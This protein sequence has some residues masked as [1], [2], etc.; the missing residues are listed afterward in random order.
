MISIREFDQ[1]IRDWNE[2]RKTL[3]LIAGALPEA[4]DLLVL[5]MQ[6]GLDFQV[7]LAH[8][9]E[10]APHGPLW[11]ELSKLQMEIRT[12]VSRVEALRHLAQR[13][14]ETGL[15]EMARAIVQGIELGSSLTSIL[16][17]QSQ[18]LRRRRATLAEKRAALA[19]LKLMFPLLVFIFPT[20]L[21]VLFTPL[22]LTAQ[23]VGLP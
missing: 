22:Y 10:K 18:A 1:R 3:P 8:Y 23:H 16:R 12:G 21:V 15:R 4:I 13:T 11:E 7:A 6:A 9:L 20:V 2:D 17:A 19:P 14:H 5:V